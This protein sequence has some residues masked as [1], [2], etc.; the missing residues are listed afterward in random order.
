MSA[1]AAIHVAKKQL[2]L[3]EDTYRAALVNITGKAS[4]RDMT[5]AERNKVVAAFRDR[6]FK[7]G[8]NGTRKPLEGRYAKKLQ[9]LWIAGWNLG[10]FRNRD[11]KALIAFVKRQTKL[12]HVQFLHDEADARKAIEAI[13]AW[14]TREA[15]VN[16]S[17]T[18]LTPP[19][20][21]FTGAQIAVAQWNILV[22]AEEVHP[23][24]DGFWKLAIEFGKPVSHIT[25][26]REWQP[27]MNRLGARV[28]KVRK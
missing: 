19:W 4:T 15:K 14:L 7:P 20:L 11:D 25:D 23:S 17:V 22:A 9:A 24:M 28:R 16:W 10:V 27:I 18:T 2:G 8:S 6:G 21:Q 12:S 3:D 5:E 26:E 13:K 1:L